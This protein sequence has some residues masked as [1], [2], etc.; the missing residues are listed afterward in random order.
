MPDSFLTRTVTGLARTRLPP[1][2]ILPIVEM[3]ARRGLRHDKPWVA[4]LCR[5][6]RSVRA[7]VEP[8]LYRTITIGPRNSR[9]SVSAGYKSLPLHTRILAI[10]DLVPLRDVHVVAFR[11][12]DVLVC[13]NAHFGQYATHVDKDPT[14]RLAPTTLVLASNVS[15]PAHL[16]KEVKQFFPS[17]THLALPVYASDAGPHPKDFDK[18]CNELALTHIHVDVVW[19]PRWRAT[20]NQAAEAVEVV[21]LFLQIPTLKR[22]VCRMVDY[23]SE[24]DVRTQLREELTSYALQHHDSRIAFDD[25]SPRVSAADFIGSALEDVPELWDAGSVLYPD[26]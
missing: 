24:G 13:S 25:S 8:I 7:V 5:V 21:V 14:L 9:N 11:N 4:T 26:V 18:L 3:A 22:I 20:S 23:D 16:L 12:I 2:L 1:E 6:C 10:R 19:S 17:L 15:S